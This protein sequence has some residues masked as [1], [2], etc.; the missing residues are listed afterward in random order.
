MRGGTGSICPVGSCAPI[1]IHPPRA[2]RDGK[3]L[4]ALH[5]P[6]NFNPP[7]PCG[8][9]R[10]LRRHFYHPA[11]FNPPAPCGAGP[12][13]GLKA[14]RPLAFQSTRPVRGGTVGFPL[15]SACL[16]YFNPPA[17]CGAG[18]HLAVML[19]QNPAISIHPPRAG[20]DD[21]ERAMLDLDK[22]FQST[23]P[24]RGGTC[25]C[26][27]R[28]R[29][30]S[31]SIHPPRAGRDSRSAIHASS[32]FLFQSTR[33]VRGGT[34]AP[35]STH[36]AAFYFNPP[37]PC[38]A[39]HCGMSTGRSGVMISIHPPRAGRDY[40]MIW[41]AFRFLKFQ[42]TRPVRGGTPSSV[43]PSAHKSF[44]STRPVRG[45]TSRCR[46][47]QS[48]RKFQ[49]TRP[50]RGGTGQH[51]MWHTRCGHFNPPAPCGAGPARED[52]SSLP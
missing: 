34:P 10:E 18:R 5:T 12:E 23:R 39:G 1:S 30:R 15:A 42:S 31:I 4:P 19:R 6:G 50:V 17:P 46:W 13:Y 49:S 25:R 8:A 44:Q 16:R 38:G 11:H 45:G 24:V 36:P 28:C 33:P 14:V 20:R 51:R 29:N 37:A 7:A 26:Q 52:A 2:G 47:P 22:E 41:Q 27:G 40:A 32:C 9:G 48:P 3:C 43:S 35:Q 21:K